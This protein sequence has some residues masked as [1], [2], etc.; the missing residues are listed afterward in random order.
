MN[1]AQDKPFGLGIIVGRFQ[2]FHLGH[3]DVIDRAFALCGAVGVFIGSSQESGTEKNPF[4]YDTR[5]ALIKKVYG[6]SVSVFPL[7]DIGVGN[8]ARW[9]EYVLEN[10]RG[11]FGRLPD[12]LI[13][14]KEE[15]RAEWLDGESGKRVF[16]LYVPKSVEVSATAMRKFLVDGD[17]ASWERYTDPALHGEFDALRAAVLGSM[18]NT[19]TASV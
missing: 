17:R 19:D 10:V 18:G 5:R 12:V 2:T 7:P 13:S 11:R 15:R 16:E 6:K 1:G 3:Q 8:T 4:S 9:G 14:G